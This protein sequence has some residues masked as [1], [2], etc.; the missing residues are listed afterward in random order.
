MSLIPCISDCVYQ[1]DGYCNLERAASVGKPDPAIETC[2]HFIK[3]KS[4]SNPKLDSV[5]LGLSSQG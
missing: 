5:H 2:I 1:E 3:S 4:S